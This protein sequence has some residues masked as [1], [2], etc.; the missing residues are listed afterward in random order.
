MGC[1]RSCLHLGTEPTKP[2]TLVGF[3]DRTPT[4]ISSIASLPAA[5]LASCTAASCFPPQQ[6][7]ENL[8]SMQTRYPTGCLRE[9]GLKRRLRC[10]NHTS[11]RWQA[12]LAE[13][14]TE[15]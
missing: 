14:Q 3:L 2:L 4:R 5:V 7:V 6:L 13:I 11:R 9:A 8:L 10:F 12:Y 1:C 15:A